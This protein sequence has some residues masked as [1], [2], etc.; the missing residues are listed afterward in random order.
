MLQLLGTY[1]VGQKKGPFDPYEA[2][3]APRLALE[4]TGWL[5]QFASSLMAL[6]HG[7]FPPKKFLGDPYFRDCWVDQRFPKLAFATAVALQVLLI[8]FPPPLWNV[9]PPRVVAPPPEMELT[10]Y[11]PV[12]DLPAIRPVARMPKSAPRDNASRNPPPRGADAYHPR[13]TIISEPLHP[14]H[15]RQTLIQPA[16]AQ[17]PPKI[18]PALPNI[19]RLANSEPARP[20]LQL[21]PEQL[22]AMRP[23]ILASFAASDTAAPDISTP[24]KEA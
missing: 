20:K 8:L 16:K 21:T 13:Q 6:V 12:K 23:K 14:T 19:V 1:D 15:P 22:P 2:P 3:R 5:N 7:P 18:L 11:G 10:W 24:Q 9:R 4:T 17:E